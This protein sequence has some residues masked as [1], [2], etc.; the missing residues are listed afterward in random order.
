VEELTERLAQGQSVTPE[1]Q[2]WL[3]E[4]AVKSQVLESTSKRLD[5]DAFPQLLMRV[6]VVPPSL[7]LAPKASPRFDKQPTPPSESSLSFLLWSI[8]RAIVGNTQER[9]GLGVFILSGG[10]FENPRMESVP[11]TYLFHHVFNVSPIGIAVENLDGRPLFVN[12]ALCSMLGFS[13]EELRSKHWV[14]FSPPEDAAK[15]WALFR[16]L[17]AGSID[18]YQLEKR[19]FRRDGSLMWGRLSLSL[20]D[21][22]PSPLV[23]AMVEDITEKK[24]AEESRLRHVALVE[25]SEDAI[26]SKNR[27][28]VIT[29]WNASAERIFGYTELEAVG[30]P[31]TILIPPEL[32]D[33]ENKILEKL[34]AGE[35]IEHYE[36]IRLTKTGKKLN[37]S[38]TLSPIRDST[39]RLAGFYKIARDTT[40]RKLA[41]EAL[42][43]SEER[44]RLAQQ[45]ARIGTFEWDIRTGVNTWTSELE[46]MYGL[47]PGGFGGTQTAFE[48]LV[49][50]DD[51]TR[52]MELNEWALKTGQPTKGEWRVVWPDGSVHWI[53]GRWQ[54]FM[55]ESGA[56]L[57]MVGVNIDVTERKLAEDRL[58]EYERA[59]EGSGEMIAVLDQE[60]RYLIANNQFL[61]MRNMTREQVVGRFAHEVLHKGFFEAVVKAKLDEC[62]QG[63]VVRYE[64]KY[65]YPELGERDVSV[66][67]FP[68]E[69]A[70]GVDRV[71]CILQDV[72]DRKRIEESLRENEQRLRLATQA[73]RMYAY[74]WDVTADVVVRSSE[75][76][77]MLGLTAPLRF[78]HDQFVDKIHP[79]DRP[80]FLAAIARLT[81]ENP[82]G[83]VT[84]RALTSDG[85]LVWLKS[86]GRG[87][88]DGEGK[89]LRVIGMVAD[90]TDLKKA[91]EALLGINRRLIEAQEEERARIGRE[92]HD[93]INQKVAV[94][95]VNLQRLK[96]DLPA[97][98]KKASRQIEEICEGL[99]ALGSDVQALSHRLHSSKLEYLGLAAACEGF[100]REFS[101]QQNAKIDFHAQDIPKELPQETALCLFRVLQEALQNAAKHSGVR[102]FAVS[103]K[104]ALNEIQLS[105]HDTGVGFDLQKAM[106]GH[107]LGF[108]S[109]KERMKLIDGHL[110]IDLKPQG[111]TTIRACAPFRPKSIG[112]GAGG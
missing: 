19:Y 15:D 60:Y 36:T 53:A 66:S 45:V 97:L 32:R 43:V 105:V 82:A 89:L 75:H 13:E 65:A 8:V 26:I 84:Y 49:H 70:N 46:S 87:F 30:Q 35:R 9:S 68:I 20:L 91:E 78:P 44:L 50:L 86:N 29:S 85:T 41:E 106:S 3:T 90:V 79:D 96:H 71:A 1:D 64:T 28:A 112:A 31:I 99:V 100:C 11:D 14:D 108:T 92:L 16:Q 74:D 76:V 24:M 81:P 57:R 2:A 104:A 42:R 102:Q 63:K 62:F 58:R 33:E 37:V 98:E 101:V 6:D 110:S 67:Y 72:S 39:G 111:G 27:D 56:P 54:V 109:M 7:S 47:P 22:R 88:F 38:L 55:N 18:H 95:A 77:E 5:S 73:G 94:L 69:G 52:V 4:L 12:P 59:V 107:G 40:K 48:N 17:Q 83:E 103:L 34:R 80:K 10:G 51:R 25:S 21:S 93:D 61:K 23:V